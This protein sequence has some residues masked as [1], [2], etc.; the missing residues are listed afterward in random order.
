MYRNLPAAR[1]ADDPLRAVLDEMDRFGVDQAMIG[2]HPDHDASRR[3][4]H[5]HAGRFIGS[6]EVDPQQ[7]VD[8]VRALRAA[9]TDLGVRAATCFTAGA[10]PPAPPP[11]APPA[12]PDAPPRRPP[13]PLFSPPALPRPP[14]PCAPRELPG[15]R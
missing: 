15:P 11:P 9:V 3:A 14:R 7:G 4:L 5:D 12:P 6:Y 13:L 8:G 2:V 10:R 1:Y